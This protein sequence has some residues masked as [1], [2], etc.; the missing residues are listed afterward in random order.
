MNK[1]M[2]W[3]G[4]EVR[5]QILT[6]YEILYKMVSITLGPNGRNVI[7]D[8]GGPR[9]LV[10]KDGVTVANH[11]DSSNPL[12]K[13]GIS[14]GKEIADKVD[15]TAGDG[16]TTSTII[17]FN[18]MKSL[19]SLVD[20]GLDVN[21]IRSGLNRAVQDSVD[22]LVKM[23]KPMPDVRT[24]AAVASNGNQEIMDLCEE[25]YGSIGENGS[26]VLADSYSK[27]GRSYVE[28]SKGIRWEGGVPSDLFITDP[29]SNT[30]TVSDP[31]VLIFASG[32]AKLDDLTPYIDIAKND[33]RPLV[34][35]APYFEPEL[36][37]QAS[38]KGVLL[39]SSPGTSFS[40]IDLHEA[41]MDLAITLGTKVIP[42]TASALNVIEDIKDA[43]KAALITASIEETKVT[44]YKELEPA[45]A[46]SYKAYINK[47]KAQID[48]DDAL[49]Q[50]RT[51]QLKD[52]LARLSGGIATIHVGAL[53]PIEK[54]EKVASIIDAQHSIRSAMNYGVL[55]G[56]GTAL[57]KVSQQLSD[58]ID[59]KNFKSESEKRA[60]KAVLEVMRVPAKMLVASL[61]PEDYQYI[62]Q[63]IAHEKDFNTGY[64]VRT[65]Q[66][67]DLF[68]SGI[69]DSAAIEINA[70]KY[71]NSV[72]GSY[73]LSDGVIY[74]GDRNMSYDV[75]DR[76][77]MEAGYGR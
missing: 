27:T 60:Y 24:I 8:D 21:D 58:D 65:G 42:D 3:N 63:Q 51:E 35:I 67:E 14:L 57:L 75:N 5:K 33:N 1:V 53:T 64:N 54:E 23:S 48:D 56:G 15:N 76:K 18:L 17:G 40:H 43:G 72:I 71:S 47:L 34:L 32:I 31:Y 41:L 20:L 68:K 25:A 69:I 11:V 73:I 16:T 10:L 66:V 77:A 22:L 74:L 29:I 62:V 26:V 38:S 44:Q 70:L 46:K 12:Y 13:I 28:V 52:R 36:F 7:I 61:K 50:S 30:T 59:N 9:P 2:N 45:H 6:G 55:P 49:S 37:T 39:L 19:N 4:T